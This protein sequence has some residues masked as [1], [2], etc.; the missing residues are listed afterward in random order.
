MQH[1]ASPDSARYPPPPL[2]AG[3]RDPFHAAH[4][5]RRA[6][7]L[8][9]RAAGR[10]RRH[11]RAARR[12]G[13]PSRGSATEPSRRGTTADHASSSRLSLI[14]RRSSRSIP[15]P[16]QEGIQLTL[17]RYPETLRVRLGVA[18]MGMESPEGTF[19]RTGAQLQRLPSGADVASGDGAPPTAPAPAEPP[20][21]PR[22]EQPAQQADALAVEFVQKPQDGSADA[23]LDVVLTPSYVYYSGGWAEQRIGFWLGWLLF[24]E[25][26]A[27]PP[28]L[29]ASP[30]P[31]CPA[32]WPRACCS[33]RR[34]PRG[35][36]L[37]DAAA[38]GPVQPVGAGHHAAGAGAAAGG[39]VRGVGAA[40]P[41]QAQAAPGAGCA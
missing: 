14:R 26:P 38:A 32:P 9:L 18:A 33:C 11:A 5:R 3:H 27:P 37:Q 15:P 12:P 28:C 10:R 8:R 7:R 31:P 36:L 39:A 22:G 21:A 35:R 1:P 30:P 19:I 25:H 23:A 41:P 34:G 29:L 20:V 13:E 24:R 16:L 2:Q 17:D 6:G 40:E 4:A